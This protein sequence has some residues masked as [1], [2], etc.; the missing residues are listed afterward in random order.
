MRFLAV[1]TEAL[2]VVGGDRDQGPIQKAELG[3]LVQD[4]AHRLVGES[5]LAIVRI[6]G[7]EVAEGGRR[8]IGLVGV[9]KM[10]PD[11][12]RGGGALTRVAVQ[13][14]EES[15]RGTVSPALRFEPRARRGRLLHPI[16][17]GVEAESEAEPA[18]EN[19]RADESRGAIAPLV[20]DGGQGREALCQVEVAVVPNAMLEGIE[21]GQDGGVR[22]QGDGGGGHGALEAHAL[23]GQAVE[24]R[25]PGAAVSVAPE[26]VRARRVEGDEKHVQAGGRGRARAG[27][28]PPQ[29]AESDRRD[30]GGRGEREVLFPALRATHGGT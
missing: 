4:G 20:E 28:P 19:E 21:S 7:K 9:V 12:E 14:A 3:E 24:A 2:A 10:E 29:P 11:E 22:R 16:I 13:P 8:L 25:R 15:E 1:V 6:A 30:Q 23:G 26:A 27:L 5:D 18:V 17:V